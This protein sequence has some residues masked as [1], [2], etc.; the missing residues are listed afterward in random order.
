MR[1]LL[2]FTIV[3]LLT[4]S[5]CAGMGIDDDKDLDPIAK[6][7]ISLR[8]GR[9][10]AYTREA[11]TEA[12]VEERQQRMRLAAA[13]RE[14]IPGMD[15]RQVRGIL[16]EP[17]DIETAGDPGQ[18]NQRWVYPLG[19]SGRF[20]LGAKRMLYFEEGKLVGWEN[21]HAQ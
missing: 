4:L 11:T 5:G 14:V 16:G 2:F 8:Q 7:A 3:T 20:G 15:M 6:V 13:D 10:P 12:D 9:H 19:L 18:G 17:F 1:S 21:A